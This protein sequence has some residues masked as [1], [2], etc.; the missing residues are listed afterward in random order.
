MLIQVQPVR[1]RSYY[2]PI[3]ALSQYS[4]LNPQAS[5]C[6]PNEFAMW[7]TCLLM[8]IHKSGLGFDLKQIFLSFLQLRAQ[9]S[10]VHLWLRSVGIVVGLNTCGGGLFGPPLGWTEPPNKPI[11][12]NDEKESPEEVSQTT[13]MRAFPFYL[14]ASFSV[15]LFFIASLHFVSF[16]LKAPTRCSHSSNSPF[17]GRQSINSLMI[18]IFGRT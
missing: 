12:G 13:S 7:F 15:R 11:E 14:L 5:I 3:F 8:L 4:I 16:Q 18:I 6:S 2:L 10:A 9:T 17:V 1:I